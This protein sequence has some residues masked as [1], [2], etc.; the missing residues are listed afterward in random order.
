MRECDLIA[1]VRAK[2]PVCCIQQAIA[3][4][5]ILFRSLQLDS[6]AQSAANTNPSPSAVGANSSPSTV[7]Q[8]QLQQVTVTGYITPRVGDGPQPVL[9]LDQDFIQKQGDQTVADVLLRLPENLNSFTP[10]Y[11]AGENYSAGASDANLRGLGADA[12]LV[13]VDGQRQVAFPFPQNQTISFADL[14]SIPLA[15]VDRI[16]VLK[17]G[18]GATY[19]SDAIAGVINIILKDSYQGADLKFYYG[20]S[21]RGDFEQY[22]ASLVGGISEQLNENSRFN[23]VFTFDFYEQAPIDLDDRGYA[24]QLNHSVYGAYLNWQSPTYSNPVFADARGNTYTVKPGTVGP[25]ITRN[26]FFRPASVALPGSN[27]IVSDFQLEPREERLGTYV[28]LNYQLDDFLKFYEEFSYQWNK[29]SSEINPYGA[30]ASDNLIVP[31]ANPFNPFGIPL[32][33]V[34]A[35]LDEFGPLKTYTTIDTVRTLTGATLLLPQNWTVD[36]SFLYAESDA[37]GEEVDN[38]NRSRLQEALDGTLPGFGGQ[39]Y[40]PFPDQSAVANPNGKMVDAI[41]ATVQ[42]NAHSSLLDW[43]VKAGGGLMELPGGQV[44]LGAGVEYRSERYASSWDQNS[45]SGNIVHMPPQSPTNGSDNVWSG[46]AELAIP[47]LGEHWSWAGARALEIDLQERYDDYNDF[48]TA[49]KPKLLLRYKPVDDLTFRLTYSEGYRAPSL[50]QLFSGTLY[51][52]GS[53]FDPKNPQ[54][55]AEYDT[56]RLS[57]NPE[58]KPETAYSYYAGAIWSPGS[59][60]PEHSW[61]GWANGFSAYIDWFQIL[62]HNEIAALAPQQ[63]VD[64]EQNLPGLVVRQANG[65]INYINDPFLNLGAVLVDGVDF[66]ATY[67]SRE[68]S[69]GKI[70]LEIGCSYQYNFAVQNI[71]SASASLPGLGLVRIQ[72]TAVYPE[73]DSY[74]L[75]DFKMVA[76]LFY[77]KALFGIDRFRAGLTLNYIDSEHDYLDNF[78]GTNPST[79]IEPN[80][81][82]HR[83]GSWTTLDL[84]VSYSFGWVDDL[85]RVPSPGYSADGKRAL[86]ENAILPNPDCRGGQ[87]RNWFGGVTLTF[88]INNL[89]DSKPPF[90]DNMFGY[91]ETTSNPIGRYFFLELEKK[92]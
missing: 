42:R 28:K 88:G 49:A 31:A 51:S 12:T 17:D 72:P 22:H 59:K 37:T 52:Y 9:T 53:I 44:T 26:D 39:F 92:F 55:G 46:Y 68:Y 25:V 71:K 58:L 41:R 10:Q 86:G 56:L 3:G 73:A 20:I 67:S 81:T 5:L 4:L 85:V 11:N 63:I 70:D 13:L 87:V 50:S 54:L 78:K 1:L 62:M 40:D 33:I 66:G 57:G 8:D 6:F 69:W 76:S 21:Q 34:R 79:L 74:G 47:I 91:D 19:G 2:L 90:S 7:N 45:A 32:T 35:R 83:V 89:E 82:V 84:Q 29:E 38:A 65:Q 75:P 77:S 36:L 80:G 14:N 16:E 64:N 24:A 43:G 27:A 30:I 15:A 60:D 61:W 18:A 48:G 23:L